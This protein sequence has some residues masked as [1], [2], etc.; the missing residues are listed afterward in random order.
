MYTLPPCP[1]PVSGGGTLLNRSDVLLEPIAVAYYLSGFE[2][3]TRVAMAIR[4]TAGTDI[5]SPI[6]F[7]T[8]APTG[9]CK[10]RS[11]GLLVSSLV[12]SCA[13]GP[14]VPI[15]SSTHV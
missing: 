13:S 12:L 2:P 8:P 14:R 11:W 6:P 10:V 4:L 15:V 9:M 5:P 1:F 3:V 7:A